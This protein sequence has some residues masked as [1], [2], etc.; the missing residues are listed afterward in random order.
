MTIW[1]RTLLITALL[2]VSSTWAQGSRST[3]AQYAGGLAAG[4]DTLIKTGTGYLHNIVCWGSD[5]AATAGT[6]D[7]RNAVAAG[8]GTVI[9]SFP[10]AAALLL[11]Q[12]VLL[13]VPFTTGLYVDFTTTNDVTCTMSYR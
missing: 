10:I 13:D 8:A 7:I 4:T 5:A 6:I 12:Q 1:I 3:E 2:G 11:P 9:L